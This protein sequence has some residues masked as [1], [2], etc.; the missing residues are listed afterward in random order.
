M[1]AREMLI[2]MQDDLIAENAAF[3]AR[4]KAAYITQ[5]D[6]LR[7][8]N[9]LTEEPAAIRDMV[10]AFAREVK[11]NQGFGSGIVRAVNGAMADVVFS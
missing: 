4:I 9:A 7:A 11:R 6:E 3:E 1:T 2:K 8:S 10:E 5:L